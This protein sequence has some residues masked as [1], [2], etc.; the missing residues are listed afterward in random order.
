ME[1]ILSK[2]FDYQK[3]ES[4]PRL[5][6]LIKGVEER[7]PQ[8]IQALSDD[9]LGKLNAAGNTNMLFVKKEDK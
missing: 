6:K 7:Y 9:E 8:E 4:N 2:L 3:Y 5:D 1:K